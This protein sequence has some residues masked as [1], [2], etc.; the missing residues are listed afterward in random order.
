MWR[1]SNAYWCGERPLDAT[2]APRTSRPFDILRARAWAADVAVTC[3]THGW[4]DETISNKERLSGQHA[5]H[6]FPPSL[7]R[8]SEVTDY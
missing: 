2:Q 8:L 6:R 1:P 3:G 5:L 7:S 4:M